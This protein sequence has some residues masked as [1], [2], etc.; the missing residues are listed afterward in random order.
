MYTPSLHHLIIPPLLPLLLLLPPFFSLSFVSLDNFISLVFHREINIE[1]FVES[2]TSE[3]TPH[4][5][6]STLLLFFFFFNFFFLFWNIIRRLFNFLSISTNFEMKF[7]PQTR[8]KVYTICYIKFLSTKEKK[9]NKLKQSQTKQM[10]RKYR[11]KLLTKK[12]IH[13][14]YWKWKKGEKKRQRQRK[15]RGYRNQLKAMIIQRV[16]P[17]LLWKQA[18]TCSIANLS[19]IIPMYPQVFTSFHKFS[20]FFTSLHMSSHVFTCIYKLFTSWW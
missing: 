19:T 7:E 12:F 16:Y 6:S 17:P 1:I 4:I 14:F 11:K 13:Y 9:W 18:T 20:Q 8:S 10:E 15:T 5:S 2:V 3:L